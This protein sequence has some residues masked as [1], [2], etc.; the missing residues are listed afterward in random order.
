MRGAPHHASGS[1]Q[2]LMRCL[3]LSSVAG[4]AS[5]T[6]SSSRSSHHLY[7]DIP[8]H[9]HTAPF[10]IA[11]SPPFRPRTPFPD[12]PPFPYTPTGCNDGEHSAPGQN[13]SS[14]NQCPPLCRWPRFAPPRRPRMSH[15]PPQPLT[16]HS[17]GPRPTSSPTTS[18]LVKTSGRSPSCESCAHRPYLFTARGEI[19]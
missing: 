9:L 6:C 17:S 18:R 8:S 4:G 11:S 13:A 12:P 2:I 3:V 19:N 1:W 5:V 15:L 14:T 10:I 16:F 7:L